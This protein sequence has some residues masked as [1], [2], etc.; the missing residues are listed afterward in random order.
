MEWRKRLAFRPRR[1][2][3]AARPMKIIDRY[4]GKELLVTSLFAVVVLSLVLV[5]GNVF[6]QLLDLLVNQDVPLEFILSFI[7]YILPF[8]L[9]FTIPWGFLTAVLLVFGKLSAENELIALKSNGVSIPRICVPLAVLAIVASLICLWINVSVAPRAQTNMKNALFNIATSNPISMFG[10][11]QVIDEF[12]GKKIYVER[13]EG[14]NLYN[15][16]VFELGDGS[17]PVRVVQAQRGRLTTDLANKQVL[18][19][20]TEAQFE[21]R[22][23][24]APFDL[25]RIRQGITMREG[26]FPISLKELYEKNK[27]RSG[28]SQKT[29]EELVKS[30]DDDQITAAHTEINKRFSFSLASIAFALVGVPLAITAHRKETSIGFLFSLMVAF[31]YFFF[32]VIAD[33]VRN[34]P[35]AHPEL[36]IWAPNVLFMSL[37]AWLYY[38]LSKK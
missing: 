26:T 22:D 20:L 32:I 3:N 27:K 16:L 17:L 10:S 18:M 4:I 36:L 38:K 31:V 5:L 6:K 7:G 23:V 30:Q 1:F 12:P 21:Q 24:Q 2:E 11:D 29:L 8:S 15:I 25:S 14:T 28:V 19:Q 13:K 34:N 9:T 37:G 35:H 33:S